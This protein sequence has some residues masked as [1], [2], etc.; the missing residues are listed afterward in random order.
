MP[1][2]IIDLDLTKF[3]E[4][5]RG[6]IN[7]THAFILIRLNGIPVGKK[8]LPV[9]N[10]RLNRKE[11]RDQ[12]FEASGWPLWEQW[13]SDYLELDTSS[14]V[15]SLPSVT[16]AVCTRDRPD[17]I[18]RCL[19]SLMQLPDDGQEILVVDNCPSTDATFHI[20]KD[21]PVVRYIREDRPG[22]SAARNRALKEASHEIVA[23]TDD[24]AAPETGWLRALVRNFEDPR[25][26]CVTGQVMPLELENK[27]QEWFEY[28]IPL[29]RGFQK[30]IFD[31]VSHNRFDVARIGV[32]ANMALRKDITSCVGNFDEVLGV[33][34]PARCGEDHDLFSRI[35]A[36]GYKIVYEPHAVNWHRHRA[37]WREL[38][39][40]LL[41]YGIGVYAFWT[42]S[43]VVEG[44]LGVIKLPF[45]WFFYEQLPN[46]IKSILQRPNCIPFDLLWMELAGCLTGPWYYLV[47]RNRM[48]GGHRKSHQSGDVT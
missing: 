47:S 4:E 12:L 9:Y 48:R 18:K 46:L 25:V 44:E 22:S 23:F 40:T 34:T 27:A 31:G 17:D 43:L 1:T 6:L 29:G 2:A 19:E 45:K 35:L 42:R 24:D 30:I 36:G 10:G 38:R 20:V 16:V 3:P 7:Y 28:Y 37:T 8:V 41:N 26:L 33:G 21:F 13:L 32:S 11:I 5:I 14:E 39:Q 15:P